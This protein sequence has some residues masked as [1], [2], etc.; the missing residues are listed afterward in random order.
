MDRKPAIR[1]PVMT[2]DLRGRIP[3]GEDASCQRRAAADAGF[4]GFSKK[5]PALIGT[6]SPPGSRGY[7]T[8]RFFYLDKAWGNRCSGLD[9]TGV[10]MRLF[11]FGVFHHAI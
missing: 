1:M 2:A 11:A 10:G 6:I 4:A 7:S 5:M 3:T 9:G 8:T